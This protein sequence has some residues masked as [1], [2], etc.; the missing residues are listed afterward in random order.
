MVLPTAISINTPTA[1]HGYRENI[2]YYVD[3]ATYLV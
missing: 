1:N 3:I 2:T